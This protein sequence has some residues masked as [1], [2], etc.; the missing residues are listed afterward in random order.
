[1]YTRYNHITLAFNYKITFFNLQLE[2]S[3]L[4]CD[5]VIN[6]DENAHRFALSG[7]LLERGRARRGETEKRV[8][9]IINKSGTK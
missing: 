3:N 8:Q 9:Q 4:K 6:K 2:N 1:M 5:F 7:E